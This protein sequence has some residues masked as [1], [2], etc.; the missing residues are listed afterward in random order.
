MPYFLMLLMFFSF[1]VEGADLGTF[2]TTFSIEEEDLILVLQERLSRV[3]QDPKKKQEMMNQFVEAIHAP[4]GREL[5]KALTPRI[6]FFDPTIV[7]KEEIKDSQG[8]TLVPKGT[9]VNPLEKTPLLEELL[10]IDGKDSA[11]V[12]WAKS[13][14]GKW[15]LTSGRPIELEDHENR[16]I[17]FDQAGYL[18]KKL[19]IQALPARVTQEHNRLR[20]E[21]IPCI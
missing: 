16:P 3:E 5:P 19:E 17:Y 9:R 6:F 11:Q 21:E 1:S 15:I 2:G 4:K 13:Q 20:I 14:Q 18:T 8:K 10:F 12:A 7:V